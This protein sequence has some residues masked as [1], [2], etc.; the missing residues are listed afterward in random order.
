[1]A[2]SSCGCGAGCWERREANFLKPGYNGMCASVCECV[3]FVS[4]PTWHGGYGAIN[5]G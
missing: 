4:T 3:S 1:M 2:V 5:L